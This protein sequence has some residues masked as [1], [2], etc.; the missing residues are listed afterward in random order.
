MQTDNNVGD[1]NPNYQND[2]Q[3]TDPFDPKNQ[4]TGPDGNPTMPPKSGVYAKDAQGKETRKGDP[5]MVA[6]AEKNFKDKKQS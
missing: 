1:G 2:A 5:D 3:A 4:Q 6:R